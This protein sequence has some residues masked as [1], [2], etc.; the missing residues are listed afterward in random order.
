MKNPYSLWLKNYKCVKENASNESNATIL[1]KK[2][3]QSSLFVRER[4]SRLICACRCGIFFLDV[5]YMY[6]MF[7]PS[8]YY[9]SLTQL[10]NDLFN[11]VQCTCA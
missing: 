4:F 1:D 9:P 10:E 11:Q 8:H 3:K 6:L 7:S 2:G 5:C